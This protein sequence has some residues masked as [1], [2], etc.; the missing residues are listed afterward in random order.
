MSLADFIL[1]NWNL[2]ALMG[3]FIAVI[4]LVLIIIANI[5]QIPFLSKLLIKIGS[6]ML[7]A[8]FGFWLVV[9]MI[10]DTFS[11]PKIWGIALAVLI[12]AF[13]GAMIF[14]DKIT[15]IQKKSKKRR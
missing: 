10:Q 14:W 2:D 1:P 12:V 15:N 7:F 4:G 11:D 9:S 8:G 13:A 3:L 6:I 5:K